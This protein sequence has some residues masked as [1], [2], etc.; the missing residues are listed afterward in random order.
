MTWGGF[1]CLDSSFGFTVL[2]VKAT[3]CQNQDFGDTSF[4]CVC[5]ST[6]CDTVDPVKLAKG[7][8]S[9]YTSTQGGDRLTQRVY[10]IENKPNITESVK[11]TVNKTQT[12]QQMLGF[13]GAFTDAAG[14]NIMNVTKDVQDKLLS[15]YFSKDGIEYSFG[16]IPMASCDF[17]THPYSYDDVVGDLGLEQFA[18]TKEDTQ[19][20]IPLIQ[21]AVNMS[22]RTI[23]LYGSPWS[24]PY[25]MKTNQNETGKG[26]LIGQPGGKYY[27][28]WAL[29]F[30]RFVEEYEKHDIKLWGLTAQ[31]EPTDGGIAKFSFQAMYFNDTL[32]RDFIKMDLGPTLKERGHGDVKLMIL[33]D[34]RLMLPHWA[35][36]VLG[37][38]DAAQFVSGIAIHWYLDFIIP[39][40]ILS[41]THN[42][43]PEHFILATEACA[44]SDPGDKPVLLGNW[45]RGESYSHDIISDLLNW[46]TGWVD[47]NIALNM[48]GGPNWVN[49]FVDSPIIIDADKN[50]FYK[51]PMYYHLGHFSKFVEPGSVRIDVHSETKN[52]LEVVGFLTSEKNI[53]VIILN[54]QKNAAAV[55]LFDPNVGY[56][57]AEVPARSIQTYIWMSP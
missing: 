44:G 50:V 31:N 14:M 18:L 16:R 27:K 1:K 46:V 20:K 4:V 45:E 56:I 57:N 29:Y 51:Q 11:F 12:F 9:V 26:A 43:H 8:F 53:V 32:Q 13:G 25:W 41:D 47:W 28:A 24:A 48:E 52:K 30:A 17:S 2:E 38:P 49:N 5:S 54:R 37:D 39:V 33:D 7:Q 35:D 10:Q 42:K 22:E 19:Y 6:L 55:N 21:R 23:S 36:T 15:S 40:G 34:N 3:E